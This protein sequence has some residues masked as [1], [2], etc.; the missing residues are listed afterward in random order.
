MS[1]FEP[2]DQSIDFIF[3]WSYPSHP[4]YSEKEKFSK[5]ELS[6]LCL[7]F[8]YL[9]FTI[10]LE[11]NILTQLGGWAT[12]KVKKKDFSVRRFAW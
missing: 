10:Q 7:Y 1:V 2:I 5:L 11:E 6:I 3:L 9:L 12:G 8:S 4:Y